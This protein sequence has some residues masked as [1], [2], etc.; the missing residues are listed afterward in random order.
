MTIWSKVAVA[1]MSIALVAGCGGDDGGGGADA[2]IAADDLASQ[3]GCTGDTDDNVSNVSCDF[4]DSFLGIHSFTS[5]SDLDAEVREARVAT[6]VLV[7]PS[8]Y[9]DAPDEET[10]KQAQDVVGGTI[11]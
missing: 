8:W 11:K 2:K 3:L 1:A 5:K 6:K 9:I 7:G 10:L 4:N